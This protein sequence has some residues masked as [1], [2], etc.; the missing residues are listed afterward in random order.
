MFPTTTST[1]VPPSLEAAKMKVNPFI[2]KR[3]YGW[4]CRKV[5]N[6]SDFCGYYCR[7]L[8]ARGRYCAQDCR[9]KIVRFL[10]K[11]ARAVTQ[12][13]AHLALLT[14]PA[15]LCTHDLTAQ[16]TLTLVMPTTRRRKVKIQ[17]SANQIKLNQNKALTTSSRLHL[18]EKS[19][20]Q[21]TS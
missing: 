3:W 5:H 8:D 16:A 7:Q 12:H 14:K 15:R 20:W 19:R 11:W 17:N 6:D 18:L 21:W 9:Q 1:P 10:V 4:I 13:Q 2:G